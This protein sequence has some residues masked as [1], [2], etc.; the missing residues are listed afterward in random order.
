[1]NHHPR[2]TS[3]C[4]WWPVVSCVEIGHT[5]LFKIERALVDDMGNHVHAEVK[6][7]IR[8]VEQVA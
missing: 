1:M 4:N 7:L 8:F 5:G 3:N 6:A 2:V